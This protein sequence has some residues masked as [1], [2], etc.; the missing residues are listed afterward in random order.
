[1]RPTGGS[2]TSRRQIRGISQ[3]GVGR[4]AR[5]FAAHTPYDREMVY[6]AVQKQRD[7]PRLLL[8]DSKR[9]LLDST[10]FNFLLP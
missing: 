5:G 10:H 1:M 8:L 4:S 6:G 7:A 2:L 9:R 3:E